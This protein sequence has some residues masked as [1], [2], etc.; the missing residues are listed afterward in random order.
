MTTIDLINVPIAIISWGV[1]FASGYWFRDKFKTL[2]SQQSSTFIL[3]AVTGV[4][5]ISVL[6]DIAS[7]TYETSPM[8]HGLMGAIVG[9]F[10]KNKYDNNDESTHK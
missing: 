2:S 1:G 6:V 10:Y 4:W 3:L 5:V 9:Y 7:P 8:L